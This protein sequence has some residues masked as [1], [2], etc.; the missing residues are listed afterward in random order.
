[1]KALGFK[2]QKSFLSWSRVRNGLNTI[3]WCQVSRDGWDDY[4][5]SKFV[6][7]FQRSEGDEPGMP[8]SRRMRLA[9]LVDDEVREFVRSIQN[10]V[11][12]SLRA[13]PRQHAPLQ[14][15]PEVA[16]WYMKK[17]EPEQK[18]YTPLDD[19]WFRYARPEHVSRWGKLI[20][21]LLPSVVQR[22]ESGA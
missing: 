7:E 17:F 15:S 6:V 1:M 20:V 14:V 8:S 5:G 12:A 21:Q 2:R 11:I 9:K 19:L 3:M 18:P 10:D 16:N 4:A 13:P 22:V